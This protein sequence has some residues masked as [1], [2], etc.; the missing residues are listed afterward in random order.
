MP[1][2]DIPIGSKFG[3]WE[4]I[5]PAI[6]IEKS[7]RHAKTIAF[8]CKCICGNIK[9]IKGFNLRKG[10]STSCRCKSGLS[11]RNPDNLELVQNRLYHTY[12]I[13]AKNRNYLFDITK[14]QLWRLSQQDCIYCGQKP[15]TIITPQKRLDQQFFYNGVDRIN[16]ELGYT[17]ANLAPA[18]ICCNRMKRTL[19][20]DEFISH[21][22]R[23]YHKQIGA[24]SNVAQ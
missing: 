13:A 4:V 20:H 24:N 2:I 10:I 3:F 18:C 14:E 8:P 11:R 17:I 12:R 5:G 16:N 23:I 6:S 1:R 15:A 22:S 9:N 19:S 7:K 21:I